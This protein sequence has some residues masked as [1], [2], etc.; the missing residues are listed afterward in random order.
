MTVLKIS[1]QEAS[2]LITEIFK[3]QEIHDLVFDWNESKYFRFYIPRLRTDEMD[4]LLH[5]FGDMNIVITPDIDS[6]LLEV[7]IQEKISF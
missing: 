3:Q 2:N 4:M 1:E 7:H 6:N 5:M